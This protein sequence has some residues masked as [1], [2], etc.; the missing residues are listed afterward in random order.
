[1]TMPRFSAPADRARFR[2]LANPAILSVA[3]YVPG[4]PLSEVRRELGLIDVVKL[5][6]NENPAGPS[7]RALAAMQGLL[8]DVHL[9]PDRGDELRRALAE[10]NGLPLA[11]V[12]LGHG[13]TDVLD[14]IARAFVCPR[15]EVISAHPSFPWYRTI[16][17]LAGADNVAVPLRAHVHD[18]EAMADR[19]TGRTKLIFVANPNNPT[20]TTV[21]AEALAGF[22]ERLPE[23]VILVLDEAYVEYVDDPPN[24][25]E[26]LAHRHV[27]VVRTFSKIAGLAGLRIGYAMA[28]PEII[29]LLE[30]VQPP[31]TTTSLAHAAALASLSDE[32]HRA[33]SRLAAR[34]GRELLCGEL[35]RLGLRFVPSQ[36]N[37]VFVDFD[38]DVAPI[39]EALLH[40]GF[41][42]RPMLETCARI[43]VG[44]A[45]QTANLV[46][47]LE[48]VLRTREAAAAAARPRSESVQGEQPRPRSVV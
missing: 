22:V 26:Y 34:V 35:S 32:D 3:P 42:V 36:A 9:Y 7:P 46:A 27:I 29:E 16:G 11:S 13:A 31:F 28:R 48:D 38:T 24:S 43:T 4:R 33:T 19:V 37:F 21:A 5:A 39:G 8:S 15:D 30:K 1:M 44:T 6:S 14:L 18:L 20:G 40:R 12:L 2:G 47:A 41:V 17:E 45:A 25:L 10:R 23:H